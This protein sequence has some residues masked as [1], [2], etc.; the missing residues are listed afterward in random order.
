MIN[1]ALNLNLR[2]GAT[3]GK[4]FPEP[5][6]PIADEQITYE[7]RDSLKEDPG[8][9]RRR[10]IEALKSYNIQINFMDRGCVIQVGCKSIAFESVEQAMAELVNYS[11]NPEV[12]QEKW[13]R[14]F[15]EY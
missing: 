10:K 15:G 4:T 11:K 2:G 13:R 8:Y 3:V 7:K 6:E 5:D 14:E 1:E 12:V 9:H